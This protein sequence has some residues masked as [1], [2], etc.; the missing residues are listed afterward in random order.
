MKLSDYL[1]E[2]VGLVKHFEG[3][4]PSNVAVY[5]VVQARLGLKAPALAR[6]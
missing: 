5:S 4:S 1:M 3:H 6:L 2:L